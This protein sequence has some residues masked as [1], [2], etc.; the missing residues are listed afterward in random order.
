MGPRWQCEWK[1][2]TVQKKHR[3]GWWAGRRQAIQTMTRKLHNFDQAVGGWGGW[4]GMVVVKIRRYPKNKKNQS[5]NAEKWKK[6]KEKKSRMHQA[7]KSNQWKLTSHAN[8]FIFLYSFYYFP[9]PTSFIKTRA[10]KIWEFFFL[11]KCPH[12]TIWESFFKYI[13]FIKLNTQLSHIGRLPLL[14]AFGEL[15]Q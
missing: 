15:S 8:K 7:K 11:A 9:R 4:F 6:K 12:D 5:I 14:H 3:Q 2:L 1:S 13:H 10:K